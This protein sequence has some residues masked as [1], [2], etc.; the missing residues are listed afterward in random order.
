[1]SYHY[2]QLEDLIEENKLLNQR[3]KTHT[4]I[5]NELELRYEN[6]L[7]LLTDYQNL[8]SNP[9][10]IT[11]TLGQWSWAQNQPKTAT[12]AVMNAEPEQWNI[13]Q[14]GRSLKKNSGPQ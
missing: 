3:L 2:E 14:S 6:L 9:P 12:E 11:T 10:V 1:M 13:F 4:L 5:Y 7:K 8:M